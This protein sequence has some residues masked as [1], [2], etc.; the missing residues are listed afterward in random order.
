MAK[1]KKP[2]TKVWKRTRFVFNS[3]FKR[4]AVNRLVEPDYNSVKV[5]FKS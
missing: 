1:N 2:Q 3:K 5:V 4:T